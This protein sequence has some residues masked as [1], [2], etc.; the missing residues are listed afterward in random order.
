M[1][2]VIQGPV[3][4]QCEQVAEVPA[5]PE[6][7]AEPAWLEAGDA[8]PPGPDG[9]PAEPVVA[10]PDAAGLPPA[11]ALAEQGPEPQV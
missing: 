11:Q 10:G 9:V 2:P 3:R 4:V 8:V 7:E 5:S 6:V 1:L